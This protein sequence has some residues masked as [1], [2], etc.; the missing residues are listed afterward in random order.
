MQTHGILPRSYQSQG[1]LH[2]AALTVMYIQL[3]YLHLTAPETKTDSTSFDWDTGVLTT[4]PTNWSL[5]A[6]DEYND[7]AADLRIVLDSS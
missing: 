7:G 5:N 2:P 6:P 4:P 1:M 3:M